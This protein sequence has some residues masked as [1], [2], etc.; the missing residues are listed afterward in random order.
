MLL[1]FTSCQLEAQKS[2]PLHCDNQT[3]LLKGNSSFEVLFDFNLLPEEQIENLQSQVDISLC[4]G[5]TPLNS[6]FELEDKK[7]E[8]LLMT[9][10]YCKDPTHYLD[11]LVP[12]CFLIR[13][14][15]ILINSREQILLDGK[16][17]RID[18][19]SQMVSN[20]SKNFFWHNSYKLVAYKILWDKETDN[21]TKF[22]VLEQTVD[23]YLQAANEISKTE[24]N[25][26]LCQLDSANLQ[27]LKR[28]FRFTILIEKNSP[29]PP[30]PDELLEINVDTIEE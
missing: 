8:T 30:P 15:R 27:V 5:A 10:W 26:E 14:K 21:H 4:N 12:T 17:V 1:V 6:K 9:D 7:I 16:L 22:N 11:E 28:K 19:I 2:E 20:L 24:F 25:L 13:S 23:G 18:S 3:I 29:I